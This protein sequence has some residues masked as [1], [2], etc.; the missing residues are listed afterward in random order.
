[1]GRLLLIWRLVARDI[2]H[3]PGEAVM[4]LIAVTAA[5][6]SLTLGMATNN[7][8]ATAYVNTRAA[9]AG[10]DI[11]VI[12]TATDPSGLAERLADA[13]G[14]AALADPVFAFDTTFRAH[15]LS[16]HTAVEGRDTSPS[17][18]D[19]PLVTSGT[20]VRPGG[21]VVERSFAQ[22]LG[23]RVGDR[24]TIGRRGYPVVGIAISAAT[25]VYPWSD[26]AQ[27]PGPSDGGGRV[28]LTTADTRAAAGDA[29][30][31][32][33]IH[34]KLS[35][36]SATE[37][38]RDTVFT[39]DLTGESW[40]NTHTWQTIYEGDAQALRFVRPTLV[41]GG[42]LLAAAALVTLAALAAVRA[43]RDNR[44]AGLLKAVGATPGTV[45]AV[46][47]A[48]YLLLTVLATALGLTA[49]TLAAPG[50]ADPSAGLL[51]TVS[52]PTTDIVV[53]A[54]FLAVLVALAG[55]LGPV[56][57]AART[58]TVHTLA[59]P[60][61]MLTPH[62]RLTAMTAYLPTSL[63]VGVRLLARRPGRAA[64]TAVG[65]AATSI[66]VTVVLT[67]HA[68]P[69]ASTD[70]GSSNLM[71]IPVD[72]ARG[73]V[74]RNMVTGQVLLGVTLALMALSV[75]NTVFLG[76]STA[77]Q[78]RRALAITRTLGATPGQVVTALC[79]AQL[80]PAVPALGA[81]IPAGLGMYWLFSG[82]TVTPPGAWL[83]TAV[84]TT[85]LAIGALTALP[86]WAHARSPAGRA[87]NAE[88]A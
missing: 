64:L 70:S 36:P 22:A 60:A 27:G 47:L 84:L 23:V 43:T 65:T 17:A 7:A 28:W 71:A 3:R 40:V 35:D 83:L 66:M 45:A 13:P 2:R 58:S 11:I 48:Q 88:P 49:G 6:A 76:W 80:L 62:P 79:T 16:A 10:P 39:D 18:V 55:T 56:L 68:S 14:V 51:N 63:L 81:G 69:Y 20:W 67:F 38:W 33:L 59:D 77:M 34:V 53:A 85:L 19:R 82:T 78:A 1:M 26:W 44:R 4:F 57:R 46:L 74:M 61:H 37:R 31:V 73:Q 9:T 15:G 30:G 12:T 21:V 5:T 41:I 25:S 32:H 72:A 50:L 87:L 75:L 86:A 24:V 29:P 52:P 8:L 54:V 42:W